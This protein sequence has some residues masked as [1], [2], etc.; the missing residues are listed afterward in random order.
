MIGKGAFAPVSKISNFKC[1]EKYGLMLN[2]K[3]SPKI[4]VI[5]DYEVVIYLGSLN[6][7]S[8]VCQQKIRHVD[9]DYGK[10]NCNQTN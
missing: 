6:T 5:A 3:S 4:K 8:G 1:I 7:N 9:V 10:N 2:K